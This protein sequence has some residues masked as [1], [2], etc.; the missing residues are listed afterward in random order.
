MRGPIRGLSRVLLL[1][2][3][4]LVSVSIGSSCDSQSSP[5]TATPAASMAQQEP[6]EKPATAAS[7]TPVESSPTSPTPAAEA[8]A[9]TPS[10]AEESAA[11]V[12]RNPSQATLAAPALYKVKFETTKGDFIIEVHR[13][14]APLGA[15]R[16]YNLVKI[17]FYNEV[18]FFRVISGFMAQ[19][20]I[21]GVP[22]IAN[23]WRSA[24]IRDD[25]VKQSNTRGMISFATAGK[26]TRTSQVF[27]NYGDNVR[28]DRMGF[29]PFGKVVEGMDVVD[30]LH[31]GY[32][33][34]AP[35]G[36]GPNQTLMTQRGNEYLSLNYPNLDIVEKASIV[37]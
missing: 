4:A 30:S 2:L 19:F 5:E 7:E 14:W 3:G 20:G 18:R 29:A 28:L 31:A 27:I 12:L 22:S 21:H 17:G 37:E 25:P 35:H 15:D 36:D 26:N 34:G 10:A 24:Q 32:G 1:S 13:D 8:P 6:A 9:E 33:E 23:K 11:K 16:F